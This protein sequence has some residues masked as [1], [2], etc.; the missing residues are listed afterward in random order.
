MIIGVGCDVVDITRIKKKLA[1]KVLT[2]KE[3]A[4]FDSY[5]DER[6]IEFLAG[7]FAA[8][9][10][11]IKALPLVNVGFKAIEVLNDE[12]GKPCCEHPDYKVWVSIA[13]EKKT[14]IAYAICEDK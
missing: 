10:A 12:M 13:H 4:I 14:A 9:E 8:K 7:R 11:I 6:Q 2:T 3:L 1:S 5:S